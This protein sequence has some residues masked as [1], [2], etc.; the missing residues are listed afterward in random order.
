MEEAMSARLGTAAPETDS[1]STLSELAQR[2]V[3]GR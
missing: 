2:I 3:K 1:V